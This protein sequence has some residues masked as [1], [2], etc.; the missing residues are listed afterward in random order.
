MDSWCEERDG[1]FFLNI[2]VLPNSSKNSIEGIIDNFLKIKIKAPAV[3]GAANKELIKFLSKK[4]KIA[5]SKIELISGKS[6]KLK[7]I[8]IKDEKI[9]CVIIDEIFM[10]K[11][12][13]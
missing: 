2:K 10:I 3:E 13:E 11:K 8:K 1:E 7:K 5:K 12:Y 4:L 6:A 9:D